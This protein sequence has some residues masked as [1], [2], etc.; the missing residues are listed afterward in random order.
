MADLMIRIFGEQVGTL[1]VDSFD[2]ILIPG[3]TQTIPL[4]IVSFTFAMVIATF[5]AMVQFA[6]VPVLRKAARVYIWIMRG[7]PVLILLLVVFYVV[8]G[9]HNGILAAVL[10]F[11]LNFSTL[12]YALILSSFD[13]VGR[14]QM[15]A[16]RALGLTPMQN[17]RYVVLPQALHNALPA[18]KFQAAGLAKSTSVVGYVAIQDITKAAEAIRTDSGQS[19][20]PLL[21]VTVI[22]FI[23]TWALNKGLDQIVKNINRI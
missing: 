1:L 12:A 7:T 22:Y 3:L 23:L 13:T 5:T 16:G 20:I 6:N 19:L 15:E 14:G 21:I 17:L 11:A 10:A 2:K 9:G 8:L 18:F 4:T